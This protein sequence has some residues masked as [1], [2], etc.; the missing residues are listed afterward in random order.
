MILIKKQKN[1][2]GFTLVEVIVVAIIVAA[3]AAVA[4][5]LY[6]GYVTSSKNNM[7]ANTAGSVASFVGACINIHGAVFN[8]ATAITAA[9]VTGEA[10][11]VCAT[12]PANAP[13]P[14]ASD[15]R[16]VIPAGINVAISFPV[17]SPGHVTGR[18]GADG[19]SGITDQ[20]YSY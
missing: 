18:G 11:L 3:L 13:A 19:A 14:T 10:T 20:V 16:I 1:Q 7:A 17:A 5:P 12:T 2:Q 15:A 6:N 9:P 8:G 4:I